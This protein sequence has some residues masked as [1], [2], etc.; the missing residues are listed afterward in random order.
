MQSLTKCKALLRVHNKPL[1]QHQVENLSASLNKIY[2]SSELTSLESFGVPLISDGQAE[3]QG[4]LAGIVAA[5]EQL[6]GTGI[7]WVFTSPVD[8]P[9]QPADLFTK[10][11]RHGQ[12]QP[13][14]LSQA[15]IIYA[16]ADSRDHPLHGLW[17]CELEPALRQYLD[18]GERR[19][20]GFLKQ[21]KA[22]AVPFSNSKAFQNLNSPTDIEAF[23]KES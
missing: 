17:S 18:S 10:L 12:D 23:E 20:M 13:Q 22:Q 1:I 2:I 3:R 21:H 15:Q 5:M 6:R 9:S 7:S 8:T 16:Q 4:P 11:Q 14:P 19:V